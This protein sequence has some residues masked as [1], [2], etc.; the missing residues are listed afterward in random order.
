MTSH[1]KQLRP[2]GSGMTFI[3]RTGIKN[4]QPGILYP[5]TLSFKTLGK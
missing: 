1:E 5:T 3:Q 2:E 4:S